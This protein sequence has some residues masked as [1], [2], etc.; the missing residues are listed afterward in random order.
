MRKSLLDIRH[1]IQFV[2]YKGL[3][4]EE[5]KPYHVYLIDSGHKI[6]CVL[7]KHLEVAQEKGMDL[8]ELSL[9]VKYVIE[10]G[11]RF[12][13]GY[14]VVVDAEFNGRYLVVDERHYEYRY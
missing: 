14:V 6:M 1:M 10:K 8:Y 13:D 11:Y 5:L 7:E 3:L 2:P 12:V 4:P 9:P